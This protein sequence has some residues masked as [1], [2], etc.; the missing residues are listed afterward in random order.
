MGAYLDYPAT[1]ADLG[2]QFAL[3]KGSTQNSFQVEYFYPL[4]RGHAQSVEIAATFDWPDKV[5]GSIAA[6]WRG[7]APINCFA[8]SSNLWSQKTAFG[9]ACHLALSGLALSF[10]SAPNPQFTVEKGPIYEMN[11]ARFLHENPDKTIAD[12]EAPVVNT[13]KSVLLFPR[14]VTCFYEMQAPV[15]KVE[16]VKFGQMRFTRLLMPIA[17]DW[18]DDEELL[19]WIY[20]N[21]K[22]LGELK[23]KPGDPLMCVIWLCASWDG[24]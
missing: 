6:K 13:E 14:N 21:N 15:K 7:K 3:A 11:L 20:V 18:D 17:R 5:C 9:E 4:M 1:D 22:L 24:A 16:S 8:Y 10:E 23:P 2:M 19:A 12:F